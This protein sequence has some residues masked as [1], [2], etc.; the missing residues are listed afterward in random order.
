MKATLASLKDRA[1]DAAEDAAKKAAALG[2][3]LVAEASR[4]QDAALAEAAQLR[5]QTVAELEEQTRDLRERLSQLGDALMELAEA[6]AE[7]LAAREAAQQVKERAKELWSDVLTHVKILLSFCQ[8]SSLLSATYA[9]Q[10]P[11]LYGNLANFLAFVNVDIEFIRKPLND[12]AKS[13]GAALAEFSCNATDMGFLDPFVVHWLCLP[14]ILFCFALAYGVT[15]TLAKCRPGKYSPD[16]ASNA[17][18]KAVSLVNFF[19]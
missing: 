19:V 11:P 8:V 15:L 13:L 9:V 1:Q 12:L 14:A 2:D 16:I 6:A 5:D 4:V 17:R 3:E 18:K 10:W 7:A